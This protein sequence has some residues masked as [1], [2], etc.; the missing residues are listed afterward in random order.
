MRFFLACAAFCLLAAHVDAAS[1]HITTYQPAPF[2]DNPGVVDGTMTTIPITSIPIA[3]GQ[4]PYGY[5]L[6][7]PPG[8]NADTTTTWPLVLC[9]QGAGE[10]GTGMNV[11]HLYDRL[12]TSG[13]LLRVKTDKWDFPAIC[14]SPQAF[15]F[16][17]AASAYPAGAT[18]GWGGSNYLNIMVDFLKQKYRVDTYRIYLTGLSGGGQGTIDYAAAYPNDLAAIMPIEISNGTGGFPVPSDAARAAIAAPMVDIPMWFVQNWGDFSY[19][20]SSPLR[21]LDDIV[22]AKTGQTSNAIANYPR[23]FGYTGPGY[24]L[25]AA[26]LSPATGLPDYGITIR[27][28]SYAITPGMTS[29]SGSFPGNAG[30]TWTG[31]MDGSKPG[32]MAIIGTNTATPMTVPIYY[33]NSTQ[34][35]LAKPYTGTLSGTYTVE[36]KLPTG[37]HMTGHHG[38]SGWVWNNGDTAPLERPTVE[39]I[40]TLYRFYDHASSWRTIWLNT[41]AWNWMF[42]Q[43]KPG[44]PIRNDPPTATMYSAQAAVGLT[45]DYYP[46]ISPSTMPD[47]SAMVPERTRNEDW[48]NYPDG[49]SWNLPYSTNYGARFKGQIQI[50]TAGNWTFSTNS[51]DGSYLLINNQ[52]LVNN[53]GSHAMQ[54]RTGTRALTAGLHAFEV[55]YYQGA[56]GY[57]L[58]ASWAGPGVPDQ[59]IP[60]SA[61]APSGAPIALREGDALSLIA[62]ASDF[63]EDPITFGWDI[64]GDGVFTDRAGSTLN[65]TWSELVGFGRGSGSYTIAVRAND[66]RGGTATVSSPITVT[67]AL[68]VITVR[69]PFSVNQGQALALQASAIRVLAPSTL[70]VGGVVNLHWDI[71]GDGTGDATG[72]NPVIPWSTLV[73]LGR[74]NGTNTVTVAGVDQYLGTASATATY[75]VLNVAP[76]VSAGGPYTVAE[77]T[78]LSLSA[79]AVDPG[80]DAVTFAWDLNG[81]GVFADASGSAP[82][83]PWANLAILGNSPIAIAVRATDVN[84]ASGQ[85]LATITVTPVPPSVT[86]GGPYVIN[87]GQPL[88]LNAVGSDSRGAAATLAWDIDGDNAFNDGT[89]AV[90]IPWATVKARG[91]GVGAHLLAVRATD[92][93]GLTATSTT[94]LTVVDVLPTVSAGGGVPRVYAINEGSSLTLAATATD[95]G[96][97]TFTFAW[98][99]NGDGFFS[100]ATGSAP[101]L[102][103]VQLLGYGLGN[104][105]HQI[106][107]QVGTVVATATLTVSN[108]PPLVSAGG[109]YSTMIRTP[110]TLAA[111]AS[112]G[113]PGVLTYAW[114]IH[115]SGDFAV[116]GAAPTLTPAQLA[117]LGAGQRTIT[118][119]ATDIDGASSTATTTLLI[120]PAPISPLHSDTLAWRDAVIA[121]G[122]SLTSTELAVHDTW[123]LD[124]GDTIAA[125]FRTAHLYWV[126]NSIAKRVPYFR[127]WGSPVL[128]VEGNPSADGRGFSFNGTAGQRILTGITPSLIADFSQLDQFFMVWTYGR[129]DPKVDQ[130]I[131]GARTGVNATHRIG[132]NWVANFNS[133]E[134]Y[135]GNSTVGL[136]NYQQIE[137]PFSGSIGLRALGGTTVSYRNGLARTTSASYGSDKPSA[138]LWVGGMNGI[139]PV[140]FNGD[141]GSWFCG[142]GLTD[143]EYILL[144]MATQKLADS[145]TVANTLVARGDQMLAP[146]SGMEIVTGAR[147]PGRWFQYVTANLAVAGSTIAQIKAA[148]DSEL[149]AA[150]NHRDRLAVVSAGRNDLRVNADVPA[151]TSSILTLLNAPNGRGRYRWIEVLP[152]KSANQDENIGTVFGN[153]RVA[154]NNAVEAAI[155]QRVV[156]VVEA[157]R[158]SANITNGTDVADLD[159]GLTP[160]SLRADSMLPNTAGKLVMSQCLWQTMKNG[161]G[162]PTNAP[163][164]FIAPLAWISATA[165]TSASIGQVLKVTPGGWAGNPAWIY[166]WQRDGVNIA[167]ATLSSYG[168]TIDD[169]GTAVRCVITGTNG[170]GVGA[171]NS[172]TITV[173]P[174]AAPVAPN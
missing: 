3:A 151:M 56:G 92:S 42:R 106:A 143:A 40:I 83:I 146:G 128:T 163:A 167:G 6:Y 28:G 86:T 95:P 26:D 165:G 155:G 4:A 77:G 110:I 118:V 20:K 49:A 2:F 97:D 113:S 51:D 133:M 147:D 138:E 94:T 46:G 82:V 80:G 101:V 141:V 36:I 44:A 171:A 104:G 38:A 5:Q 29:I 15:S 100:D 47:Y 74:T 45:V 131:F 114:D 160:T 149:L 126:G 1:S 69:G 99:L 170:F 134:V 91:L 158:A 25:I 12:T 63:N 166:Q 120:D 153:R 168:T 37:K 116:L 30:T 137:G 142:K 19:P 53:D 103:W 161:L 55:R 107:V 125:K 16:G 150:V 7:L 84:G 11:T 67:N 174:P 119:R 14:I 73:S 144:A 31:N 136:S 169:G 140:Y 139:G 59:V 79:A 162:T 66:G 57:G 127:R 89:G 115:G 93:R 54:V 117:T 152:M 13:P 132:V 78:A 72:T 123:R 75:T 81:D 121:A 41:S 18:G 39:R 145:L 65:L 154:L 48:V 135:G 122:G 22:K 61:F 112:D 32:A 102:T 23:V 109:P 43:A 87:E 70:N 71:N 85:A 129:K 8:Y 148:Q 159:M 52:L 33:A 111:T 21:W 88:V 124:I 68:P 173:A 156:R 24:D 58:I 10:Y 130:A 108:L 164:S 50:P 34:I 90:Q 60:K 96:Q 62:Y 64:N 76:T 157:M 35:F 9:L 105:N 172:N 17:M 27:S 98:D